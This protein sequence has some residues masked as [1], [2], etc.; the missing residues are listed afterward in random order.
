M[1]AI[2]YLVSASYVKDLFKKKESEILRQVYPG[3]NGLSERSI[4]RY[5]ATYGIRRHDTTLTSTDLRTVVSAAV[6]EVSVFFCYFLFLKPGRTPFAGVL[7]AGCKTVCKGILKIFFFI[8]IILLF[9]LSC[10]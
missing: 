4:S 9:S 8:Q 2:K 10:L 1:A 6:A 3:E 7:G 5:Y